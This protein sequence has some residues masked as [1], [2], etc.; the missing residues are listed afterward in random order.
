MGWFCVTSEGNAVVGIDIGGGLSEGLE[1]D[2][3]DDG[4]IKHSLD[5]PEPTRGRRLKATRSNIA[6]TLKW[7]GNY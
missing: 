5:L 2:L 7:E 1:D 6:L 3:G 4:L